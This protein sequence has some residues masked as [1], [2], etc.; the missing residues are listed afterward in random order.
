MKLWHWR[1]NCHISAALEVHRR[2]ISIVKSK[3][4][5][6][7]VYKTRAVELIYTRVFLILKTRLILYFKI[8]INSVI[9]SSHLCY[10]VWQFLDHRS[11]LECSLVFSSEESSNFPLVITI[12]KENNKSLIHD[13]LYLVQQK[14][15]EDLRDIAV[16]VVIFVKV[17]SLGR[18]PLDYCQ[19]CFHI[20][21][22]HHHI[23]FIVLL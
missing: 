12:S 1:W 23:L 20:K 8:H 2:H 16:E 6:G 7:V 15:G 18:R 10:R 21:I 4:F 14:G 19:A 5:P 3:K 11:W 9:Y 22:I 13:S 17:T